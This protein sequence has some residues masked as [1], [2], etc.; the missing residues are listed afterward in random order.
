L[1]NRNSTVVEHSPHHLKV[2][3]LSLAS[4]AGTKREKIVDNMTLANSS[5][6][7]VELSARYLRVEGLSLANVAGTKREKMVKE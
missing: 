4:A 1:A 3:G 6:T 2:E 5:S 7:V